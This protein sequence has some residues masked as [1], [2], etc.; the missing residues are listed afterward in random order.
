MATDPWEAEYQ[1]WLAERAKDNERRRERW[2][3]DPEYRERQRAY[4][5]A[6]YAAHREELRAY[7]AE[8]ARQKRRGGEPTYITCPTCGHKRRAT[9]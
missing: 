6:Y 8:W 3:T 7:K 4:A 9:S 1:R 2:A 5:R